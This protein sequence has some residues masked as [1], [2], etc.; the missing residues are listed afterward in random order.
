M[1][2]PDAVG[3]VEIVC[4]KIE[5]EAKIIDY[6]VKTASYHRL[7]KEI[8]AADIVIPDLLKSYSDAFFMILSIYRTCVDIGENR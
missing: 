3:N 1:S 7:S 4:N 2:Y 6:E 8:L 5:N